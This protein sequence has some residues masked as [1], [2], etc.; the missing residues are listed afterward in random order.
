MWDVQGAL[1]FVKLH[2]ELRLSTF[3][4]LSGQESLSIESGK[5]KEL[6]PSLKSICLL[7]GV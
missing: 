3:K 6:T 5:R 2:K 7:G 1:A 4:I